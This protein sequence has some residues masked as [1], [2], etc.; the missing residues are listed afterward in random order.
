MALL[1]FVIFSFCLKQISIKIYDS[2]ASILN[3]APLYYEPLIPLFLHAM[4]EV[5]TAQKN[6][7]DSFICSYVLFTF[8]THDFV[9]IEKPER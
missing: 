2:E 4:L 6:S 5:E 7:Y 1:T 8:K 9:Q 3:F